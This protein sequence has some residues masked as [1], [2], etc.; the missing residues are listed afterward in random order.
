MTIETKEEE[1]LGQVDLYDDQRRS[2][3]TMLISTCDQSWS[4]CFLA[5]LKFLGN[6]KKTWPISTFAQHGPWPICRVLT[7]IFS[8]KQYLYSFLLR[9]FDCI[10]LGKRFTVIFN[11]YLIAALIRHAYSIKIEDQSQREIPIHSQFF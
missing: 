4:L 8:Y 6:V 1:K 2:Y 9:K 11:R 5:M 10:F 7:S 3:R